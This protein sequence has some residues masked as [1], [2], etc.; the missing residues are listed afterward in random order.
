LAY[1]SMANLILDSPKTN[2][3]IQEWGSCTKYR[4]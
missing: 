2:H 1:I 4:M 3:I